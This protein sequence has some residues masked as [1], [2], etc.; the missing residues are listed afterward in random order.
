MRPPFRL[1]SIP[2]VTGR[3]AVFILQRSPGLTQEDRQ[4]FTSMANLESA[5]NSTCMEEPHRPGEGMS[6]PH[7]NL[8]AFSAIAVTYSY[9]FQMYVEN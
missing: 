7:I 9:S 6:A 2:G 4:S 5:T 3:E 8:I 1:K